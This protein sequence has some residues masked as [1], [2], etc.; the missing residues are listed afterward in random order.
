MAP[1]NM[2]APL[3]GRASD[4]PCGPSLAEVS[5]RWR[6]GPEGVG[7]AA[8]A[9]AAVSREGSELGPDSGDARVQE[10]AAARVEATT[11]PSSPVAEVGGGGGG[12]S[13]R[14]PQERVAGSFPQSRPR[15][16]TAEEDEDLDT[17][18][19][20]IREDEDAEESDE[21]DQY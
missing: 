1:T 15:R 12:D 4:A 16:V 18:G 21:L 3:T 14:G 5:A 19:D 8:A 20:F 2:Q 17:D 13:S 11:E 7:A 10:G 6:S 9:A